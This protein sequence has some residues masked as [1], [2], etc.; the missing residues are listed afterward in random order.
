MDLIGL[1]G[2]E[3]V[4]LDVDLGGFQEDKRKIEVD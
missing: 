2:L 4:Y 3:P 1:S